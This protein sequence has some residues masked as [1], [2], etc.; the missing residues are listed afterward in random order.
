MQ[1]ARLPCPPLSLGVCSNSCPLNW[2][3]HPTISPSVNPFSCVQ[4]FPASGSFPMSWLF[5]SGGQSEWNITFYILTETH[6]RR[7]KLLWDE[8]THIQVTSSPTSTYCDKENLFVNLCFLAG[9][10]IK[11]CFSGLQA[12]FIFCCKTRASGAGDLFHL[13][14]INHCTTVFESCPVLI[15]LKHSEKI[16]WAELQDTGSIP[17]LTAGWINKVLIVFRVIRLAK[18]TLTILHKIAWNNCSGKNVARSLSLI[19]RK[20]KTGPDKDWGNQGRFSEFHRT[21]THTHTESTLHICVF[22]IWRV[23]CESKILGKKFESSKKQNLNLPWQLFNSACLVFVF[24]LVSKL[25]P[26]LCDPMD[27]STTG[28]SVHGILQA[29]IRE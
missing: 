9:D 23:N 24:C 12:Q 11:V 28:S 6:S 3:C 8:V 18:G 2:W 22:C 16:I 5:A 7:E 29:R 13:L 4:S 17:K 26:T 25:C 14:W 27:C 1:H 19:A 21:I 10:G 15:W 20:P